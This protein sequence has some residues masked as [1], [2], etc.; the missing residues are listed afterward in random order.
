MNWRCVKGGDFAFSRKVDPK[1][2]GLQL[3]NFNTRGVLLMRISHDKTKGFFPPSTRISAEFGRVYISSYPRKMNGKFDEFLVSDV[4]AI[5]PVH[6]VLAALPLPQG[7][8]KEVC[9]EASHR[10]ALA[11]PQG[12]EVI[13]K[14]D[15]FSA[16]I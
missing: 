14:G 13:N 6:E 7:A 5:N 9:Q 4:S 15:F 11:P 16:Q 12:E 2:S 3:S 1:L 10:P 8:S